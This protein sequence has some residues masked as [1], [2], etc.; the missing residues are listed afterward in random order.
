MLI[1]HFCLKREGFSIPDK[2][3]GWSIMLGYL[4]L[5]L[6]THT[7]PIRVLESM[8]RVNGLPDRSLSRDG[9]KQAEPRMGELCICDAVV[10]KHQQVPCPQSRAW[11]FSLLNLRRKKAKTEGVN[12]SLVSTKAFWYKISQTIGWEGGGE[13]EKK[14]N[15]R[16]GRRKQG[17]RWSLDVNFA[18]EKHL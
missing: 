2:G 9:P 10:T 5:A 15:G 4:K 1:E 11:T 12:E 6:F 16:E 14:E 17:K 18:V 8:E 7:A 3:K 13:R